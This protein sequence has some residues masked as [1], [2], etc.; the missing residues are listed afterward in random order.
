M[1][2]RPDLIDPVPVD[3]PLP[4]DADPDLPEVVEP[5]DPEEPDV[6]DPRN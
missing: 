6:I 3:E 4:N 5:G 1:T 2:E